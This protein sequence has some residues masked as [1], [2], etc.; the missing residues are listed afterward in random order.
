MPVIIT[1][2]LWETMKAMQQAF[3]PIIE[4]N[5]KGNLKGGRIYRL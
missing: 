3:L 1:Y 4:A 2:T 5:G